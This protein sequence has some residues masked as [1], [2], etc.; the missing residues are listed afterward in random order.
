MR[1][2]RR[3]VAVLIGCAAWSMAATSVAYA[4]LPDPGGGPID[5]PTAS[6]MPVWQFVVMAAL[7]VLM[8]VAVVGLVLSLRNTGTP[9][10]L[11]RSQP[12]RGSHA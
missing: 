4:Q 11:H 3:L 5:D 8:A 9:K 6:N 2:V 12:T 1:Q 7:G 10:P